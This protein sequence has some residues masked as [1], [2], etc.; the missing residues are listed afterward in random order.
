ML[1]FDDAHGLNIWERTLG[2]I[3]W[4][5]QMTSMS[6]IYIYTFTWTGRICCSHRQFGAARSRSRTRSTRSNRWSRSC[7]S[8][9]C[10]FIKSSRHTR[11]WTVNESFSCTNEIWSRFSR[12]GTMMVAKWFCWLVVTEW[13]WGALLQIELHKSLFCF[14]RIPN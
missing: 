9:R 10:R 1:R 7:W 11:K 3:H 6:K 13:N 2:W 12:C 5:P 14:P 8:T 4:W